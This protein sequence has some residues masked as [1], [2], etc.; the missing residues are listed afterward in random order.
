MFHHLKPGI[1]EQEFLIIMRELVVPSDSPSQREL[2][3]SLKLKNFSPIRK[4]FDLQSGK[5]HSKNIN[6]DSQAPETLPTRPNTSVK[7][8]FS[9]DEC[10]DSVSGNDVQK[11][12]VRIQEIDLR[13]H[14]NLNIM[15]EKMEKNTKLKSLVQVLEKRVELKKSNRLSISRVN[16]KCQDSCVLW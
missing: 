12:K 10:L 9:D 1:N 11:L 13:I 15:E 8:F 14:R 7:S 4:D 16:C 5:L 6:L 3:F 2:I